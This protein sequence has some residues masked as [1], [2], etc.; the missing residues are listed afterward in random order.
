[1]TTR[2]DAGSSAPADDDDDYASSSILGCG[3]LA[4]LQVYGLCC[5]FLET[6]EEKDARHGVQYL[7]HYPITWYRKKLVED[8]ANDADAVLPGAGGLVSELG[9]MLGARGK[10]SVPL[11]CQPVPATLT[12]TDSDAHGP[13]LEIR[14]L[15]TTAPSGGASAAVGAHLAGGTPWW[16]DPALRDQPPAKTVPLYLVDK[17]AAPSWSVTGD[18]E[19][20]VR[21]YAAPPRA[22]AGGLLRGAASSG[23]ELLRF[24]TLGGGGNSSML[25]KPNKHSDKVILQL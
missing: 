18:S 25:A 11:A 13:T 16:E 19:G 10:K 12:V 9:Q 24:D 3:P 4:R 21:I 5:F 2:P 22:K 23:A 1:M 8:L 15:E 17:V 14:A 7:Y 20:G 6:E